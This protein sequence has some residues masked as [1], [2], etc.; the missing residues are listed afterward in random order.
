MLT[1]EHV[2][3]TDIIELTIDGAFTRADFDR[4]VEQTE[5]LI[6]EH[7]TLR[8]VEIIRGIGTIEPSALWAD[9]KW[10]P[11]H[12]R[13]F[14]RVAVVADKRWVSWMVGALGVFLPMKLRCFHHDE[15]DEA[16]AWIAAET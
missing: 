12:I 2:P 9:L 5:E 6:R 16:R 8:V 13:C 7:G 4:V 10:E 1:L 3:G 14:S 11:R 15:L